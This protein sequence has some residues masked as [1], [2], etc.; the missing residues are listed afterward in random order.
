MK[1]A[2]MAMDLL[3]AFLVLFPPLA[4]G[5]VHTWAFTIVEITSMALLLT[6]ALRASFIAPPVTGSRDLWPVYACLI[7]FMG[8]A[9]LQT[10][11]LPARAIHLLSP[12]AHELYSNVLTGYGYGEFHMPLSL[13]PHLTRLSVAKLASYVS[14]F[15]V[16]TSHYR[17]QG[18]IQRILFLLA[19]AG[20]A[21]SLYGLYGYFNNSLEILGYQRT[22]ISA[23]ANGTFVN[24]N[25]YAGYLGMV[26]FICTGLLL[27]RLTPKG[28]HAY[29]LRHRLSSMLRTHRAMASSLLLLMII[30]MALGIIFSMSRAGI[31]SLALCMLIM[32]IA[33]SL[34]R[35]RLH[36]TV[37]SLI[38]LGIISASLLYG[39]APAQRRFTQAID[40][41]TQY[42]MPAWQATLRM[43]HDYPVVG[44]GLGTF[45]DAFINYTPSGSASR[46]AHAHN[47]YLQLLSDTGATGCL[48]ALCTALL[49]AIT[50]NKNRRNASDAFS[51]WVPLGGAGAI[52]YMMIHSAADFNLQIPSNAMTFT[53]ICALTYGSLASGGSG[54]NDTELTPSWTAGTAPWSPQTVALPLLLA[55]MAMLLAFSIS[56]WR[57]QSVYPVERSFMREGAAVDLSDPATEE[58]LNKAISLS[59]ASAAHHALLGR[60]Y[61]TSA[62]DS[63]L[64]G[65]ERIKLMEK[66]KQKYLE[67]LRLNPANTRVLGNLAWADFAMGRHA[68]AIKWLDTA[69]RAA[70]G[71]YYSHISYAM[72]VTRFLDTIP[73]GLRKI[74][75]HRAQG[76]FEA[77]IALNPSFARTPEVLAGMAEA[78]IREGDTESAIIQ[79]GKIRPLNSSTAPDHTLHASLLIQSGRIRQGLNKYARLLKDGRLGPEDRAR[80]LESLHADAMATPGQREMGYMLTRQY[81][82]N[83]NWGGAEVVIS[84]VINAVPQDAEAFYLRGRAR[85]GLGRTGLAVDDYTRALALNKGHKEASSGLLRLLRQTKGQ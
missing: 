75:L 52:A 54:E 43:S 16:L 12:K 68:P 62:D 44:T 29:G 55:A 3:V 63:G 82:D 18:R 36:T 58:R 69:L 47:D 17:T 14:V 31:L 48:I 6:W 8:Y 77:A 65:K 13:T 37:L 33:I 57:A 84:A 80:V 21:E 41:F 38:I 53:I 61:M 2:D 50:L 42:R 32:F 78:F 64:T 26:F 72:S 20:F 11:P 27:A 30:T 35:R 71:D 79:L 24:R 76:E 22:G 59:P 56:W 74:F 39:I 67:A 49:F 40:D 23:A 25:H 70:P 7:L 51:Q 83:G 9:L 85:E 73:V 46:Y 10:L 5:A 28:T 81:L 19:T 15:I 34:R 66:A 4:F 1:V 60:Y 45:S